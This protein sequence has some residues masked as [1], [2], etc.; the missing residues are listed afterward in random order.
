MAHSALIDNFGSRIHLL[1]FVCRAAPCP[2]AGLFFGGPVPW[3]ADVSVPIT[4]AL[5]VRFGLW[6]QDCAMSALPPK[7]DMCSARAH[8]CFGPIAD[9]DMGRRLQLDRNVEARPTAPFAL[10]PPSTGITAPLM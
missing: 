9:I 10:H 5:N 7:A 8:V 2:G 4:Q 1:T 3:V 6:P